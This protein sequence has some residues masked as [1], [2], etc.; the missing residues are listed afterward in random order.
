MGI[1]LN[2]G[3]SNFLNRIYNGEAP[4]IHNGSQTR[5]FIYVKDVAAACLTALLS[6]ETGVF[7]ISSGIE[8]TINE[9]SKLISHITNIEIEP[10]VKELDAAEIK[11]SVLSNEKA[12]EKLHWEPHYSLEEGIEE[13][14]KSYSLV[15]N[16]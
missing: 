16:L 9:V 7:H 15:K 5:D 4:I 14:I 6:N 1:F 8:R 2:F 11:R 3:T 10:I 13:I 12:R